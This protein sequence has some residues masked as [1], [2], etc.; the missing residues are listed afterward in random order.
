M[1]ATYFRFKSFTAV[2]DKHVM[3]TST[4]SILLRV[5]ADSPCDTADSPRDAADSPCDAADSP[6]DAVQAAAQNPCLTH[7][8][9]AKVCLPKLCT[10]LLSAP[11]SCQKLLVTWWSMYP[12]KALEDRVVKPLQSYTTH[13]LQATKKLTLAVMNAIKV[14]AKVEEANMVHMTLPPEA[15]YNQLISEKMD[16]QDHYVAWR[17]SQDMDSRSANGT[18]PFSFCSFPFLLDAKAK[19]RLLQVRCCPLAAIF[20]GCSYVALTSLLLLLSGM[21]NVCSYALFP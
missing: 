8:P 20:D 11:P 13:E 1:K 6:C 3:L 7:H 14:L 9:Y 21:F 4:D 19:T 16:M 5:S 17:Q 10:A 18:G 12:G 2:S 15:F